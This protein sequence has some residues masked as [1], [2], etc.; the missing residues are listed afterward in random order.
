M[1]D[2]GNINNNNARQNWVGNNVNNSSVLST[3]TPQNNSAGIVSNSNG[4]VG[5]T[6]V[7]NAEAELESAPSGLILVVKSAGQS[8]LKVGDEVDGNLNPIKSNNSSIASG[9]GANINNP[10]PP[11]PIIQSNNKLLTNTNPN[12][13]TN[14]TTNNILSSS[15][16]GNKNGPQNNNALN[17][18]EKLSDTASATGQ[19]TGQSNQNPAGVILSNGGANSLSNQSNTQAP[20]ASGNSNIN[21]PLPA[22]NNQNQNKPGLGVNT[23]NTMNK[24]NPGSGDNSN[25]VMVNSVPQAQQVKEEPAP[26]VQEPQASP[27]MEEPNAQ[28]QVAFDEVP[29]NPSETLENMEEQEI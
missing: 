3:N 12:N 18:N 17:G 21:N 15:N 24:A 13:A 10:G 2:N 5:M 27:V 7:E 19:Q 9:N 4:S 28:H 14:S 22:T 1:N 29:Q 16:I 8:N 11:S 23:G 25:S 6:V 20:A 26:Q